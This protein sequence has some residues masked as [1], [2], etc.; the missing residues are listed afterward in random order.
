MSKRVLITIG[1]I[2]AIGVGA[3]TLVMGVLLLNRAN[4]TGRDYDNFRFVAVGSGILASSV[5][6]LIAHLNGA[7]RSLDDPVN[8]DL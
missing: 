3:G 8:D 7:F 4:W 1:I 5:A 2:L 6:A